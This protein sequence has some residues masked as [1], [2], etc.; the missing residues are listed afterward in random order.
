MGELKKGKN[1]PCSDAWGCSAPGDAPLGSCDRT[2]MLRTEVPG[3][4]FHLALCPEV[5]MPLILF[6]VYFLVS[7]RNELE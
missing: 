4:G 1:L 7:K 6:R 5:C 2:W 3:P